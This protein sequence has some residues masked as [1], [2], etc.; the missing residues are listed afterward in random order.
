MDYY[1]WELKEWR[2]SWQWQQ[3]AGIH[4]STGTEKVHHLCWPNVYMPFPWQPMESSGSWNHT[5]C[6]TVKVGRG[7]DSYSFADMGQYLYTYTG[8]LRSC[9]RLEVK[10]ADRRESPV[11]VFAVDNQ[12]M[13]VTL[14]AKPEAP[15]LYMPLLPF[16]SFISTSPD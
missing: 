15:I 1:C 7:S 12:R 2:I 6:W 11:P 9:R 16:F 3:T 5:P 4:I 14:R 13:T 8:Y 10:P